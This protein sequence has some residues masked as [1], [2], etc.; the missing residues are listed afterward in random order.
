MKDLWLCD[1]CMQAAIYDDF[2]ALDHHLSR[3]ASDER[4]KVI[5]AG[6][7]ELGPNL[8]PDFDPESYAGMRSGHQFSCAC[9]RVAIS[10]TR[11]RFAVM[12]N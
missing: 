10:R 1:D 3:E 11:Y 12:G 4:A 5:K 6:L 7:A 2:T 9:C 8:V